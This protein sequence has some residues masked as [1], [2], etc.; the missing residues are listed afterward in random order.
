HPWSEGLVRVDAEQEA[1]GRDVQGHRAPAQQPD[2]AIPGGEGAHGLPA[3]GG[4]TGSDAGGAPGRRG[5]ERIAPGFRRR[6]RPL[7]GPR[8]GSVV[9]SAS[10]VVSGWGVAKR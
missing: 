2:E 10:E 6:G 3:A 1:E 4:G 9:L 7:V 8:A 5:T